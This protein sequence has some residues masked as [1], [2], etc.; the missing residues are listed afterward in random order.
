MENKCI[1]KNGEKM[2]Y[3]AMGQFATQEQ[4]IQRKKDIE[5]FSF[6]IKT[7][8]NVEIMDL[9]KDEHYKRMFG[10]QIKYP[11]DVQVLTD[12]PDKFMT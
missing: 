12:R 10:N 9:N 6:F 8:D 5:R 1:E 11:F 4:A 3:V 2:C 7:K